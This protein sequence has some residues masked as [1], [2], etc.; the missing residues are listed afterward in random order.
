MNRQPVR[1]IPADAAPTR[2]GSRRQSTL[3]IPSGPL[4][5]GRRVGIAYFYEA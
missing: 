4:H 2:L 3:F 5:A 1:P